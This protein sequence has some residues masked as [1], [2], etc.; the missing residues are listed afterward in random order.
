MGKKKNKRGTGRSGKGDGADGGDWK[1]KCCEKP[2][3]KLCKR[4][5]KRALG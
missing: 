3:H 5:P 4:C 2:P 1:K